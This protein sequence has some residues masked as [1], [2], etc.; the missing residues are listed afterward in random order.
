MKGSWRKSQAPL[1][2]VLPVELW[3]LILDEMSDGGLVEVAK[4][5]RALNTLALR[6]YFHRNKM[7]V[8]QG[9]LDIR[10]HLLRALFLAV[11][12]PEGVSSLTVTFWTFGKGQGVLML[13][14]IVERWPSLTEIHLNWPQNI[15][16][17]NPDLEANYGRPISAAVF[18]GALWEVLVVVARRGGSSQAIIVANGTLQRCEMGALAAAKLGRARVELDYAYSRRAGRL[19]RILSTILLRR[20]QALRSV[21]TEVRPRF[22]I[23]AKTGDI[24]IERMERVSVAPLNLNGCCDTLVQFGST[25]LRLQMGAGLSAADISAVLPHIRLP[26]LTRLEIGSPDI[27]SVALQ[28]FIDAHP[29]LHTFTLSCA[30]PS[31]PAHHVLPRTTTCTVAA[32]EHVSAIPAFLGAFGLNVRSPS[33]LLVVEF[34]WRR[35]TA[36]QRAA[37]AAVFACV[38]R[39]PAASHLE[40]RLPSDFAA[41]SDADAAAEIVALG[42]LVSTALVAVTCYSLAEARALLPLLAHLPVLRH[43][44]MT[45]AG[46]D[47]GSAE[48]AE[49]KTLARAALPGVQ[50]SVM[51]LR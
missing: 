8:C 15:L 27:A 31:S 23:R 20:E 41:S 36:E 12:R 16:T 40:L 33:G 2:W 30:W 44:Q 35:I 37:A 7:E 10:S 48:V 13:R 4:V 49:V 29:Q 47:L 50:L 45:L 42:S 3:E 51:D 39:H 28:K 26:A 24:R 17:R 1:E 25:S 5:C 22:V 14:D 11:H 32:H 43:L 6:L 21:E 9:A 34:T 18:L 46:T 38:G 19:T